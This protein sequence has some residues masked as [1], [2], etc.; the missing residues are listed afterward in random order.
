MKKRIKPTIDIR[1]IREDGNGVYKDSLIKTV[2]I[3]PQSKYVYNLMSEHYIELVFVLEEAVHFT[4]GDYIDDEL[5]G[6]FYIKEEQMPSDE[7]TTDGYKYQLKFVAWYWMWNNYDCM[8]TTQLKSNGVLGE[9]IRKETQWNLTND[10]QHQLIEVCKNLYVLGYMTSDSD[11][12]IARHITIDS[13]LT[14]QHD[15]HLVTYSDSKIIDVL[16]NCADMWGCEWWVSGTEKDFVIHFG[17]CEGTGGAVDFKR[18]ENVESM[19]IQRNADTYANKFYVFG[20]TDNVPSTYRKELIINA[21]FSH[22]WQDSDPNVYFYKLD[23][24]L[25]TVMFTEE[26]PTMSIELPFDNIT[27][28]NILSSSSNFY[29]DVVSNLITNKEEECLAF[30]VQD[31]KN[32]TLSGKRVVNGLPFNI[33]TEG[34]R[35]S[36]SLPNTFNGATEFYVTFFLNLNLYYYR[37]GQK[38]EINEYNI[39]KKNVMVIRDHGFSHDI[40]GFDLAVADYDIN[41]TNCVMYY[42]Y[43]YGIVIEHYKG[44]TSLK[45]NLTINTYL[46]VNNVTATLRTNFDF[47]PSD[48]IPV[49][50]NDNMSSTYYM[51]INPLGAEPT[52]VALYQSDKETPLTDGVYTIMLVEDYVGIPEAYYTSKYDDSS[53]LLQLGDKRLQCPITDVTTMPSE[54]ESEGGYWIKGNWAYKDGCIVRKDLIGKPRSIVEMAVCFDKIYPDAKLQVTNDI[55]RESKNTITI[56]GDGSKSDM[57]WY[58]YHI[59]LKMVDGTDF[60]FK[61]KYVLDSVDC[62]KMRFLVPSDIQEQYPQAYAALPKDGYGRYTGFKLSG[63]TFDLGFAPNATINDI[64]GATVKHKQDFA[65]VR[66]D[67]FGAMLPNDVL[68]PNAG[69]L[70]VLIGWNV[71]AMRSLRIIENAELRLLKK[72]FEYAQAVEESQ[73]TTTCTMMSSDCFKKDSE[74]YQIYDIGQKVK[75]YHGAFRD[76]MKQ[77]RIIGMELKLDMP[78]DTPRYT[79]GETDAYSRLK[80]IEKEITRLS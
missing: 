25:K 27:E 30:G 47:T 40:E 7:K 75:L 74:E 60:V 8:M 46:N 73:F 37:N 26:E 5:F 28:K 39:S 65:I 35:L 44:N 23:K 43:N 69:D 2:L 56:Y 52:L 31:K 9:R 41:G 66:N 10:L 71:K 57:K 67:S 62:L 63:M 15:S 34:I 49:H 33:K 14:T 20:S 13:T 18:S 12:E 36:G 51:V 1:G 16:N 77:S 48:Y 45:D 11:T 22:R 19:S 72:G 50:L 38:T 53:S 76:G 21:T 42:E 6:R 32:L 58:Q 59:G 4:I 78:Y 68:R 64:T 55:Y 24:P 54:Y 29:K 17:K 3:T 61:R 80:Q 70:C 79:V